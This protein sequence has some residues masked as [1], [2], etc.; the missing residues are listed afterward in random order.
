MDR[1]KK[2][3]LCMRIAVLT[4][5]GSALS[6]EEAKK[7]GLYLVPLQVIDGTQ[8]FQ[9]GID[10][11]REELYERLKQNHT[12]KTSMPTLAEIERMV[13]QIKA[14]GYE[15]II[16]V[17]LSSGLS[18]TYNMIE[19]AGND[20]GM[21]ICTI[22]NYTTCNLQGYLAILAQS[23]VQEGKPLEE[24]E[25]LLKQMIATSGTLILPND[26]QHLK[27]GG[28]LTPLA[29]AAASLLKIKPVLKIDPETAGKIDVFEKVRTEKK[30]T[31]FAIDYICNKLQDKQGRIYVIHSECYE[32][33]KAIKEAFEK[34]NP[35]L[36]VL[37]DYIYPV[38]SAHTGLDCIAI[39]Y[40]EK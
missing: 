34:R 20:F 16:S 26:L 36:E 32:K 3:V 40:I 7:H 38:I 21:K 35:N 12:P 9:D 6:K 15:A 8:S 25:L 37:I 2:E 24:I 31:S 33:A 18:S 14:D 19:I 30:A 4:D 39:Q 27:R 10:I 29:A 13:Q 22:E 17:P 11:S 1:S 5:S 23:Y 28:R